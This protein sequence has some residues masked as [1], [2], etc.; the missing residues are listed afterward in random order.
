MNI[1]NVLNDAAGTEIVVRSDRNVKWKRADGTDIHSWGEIMSTFMRH[2]FKFVAAAGTRFSIRADGTFLHQ[3]AIYTGRFD[4]LSAALDRVTG[5][6][7]EECICEGYG[8]CSCA[9]RVANAGEADAF[10]AAYRVQREA[11]LMAE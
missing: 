2:G 6:L 10:D 5:E 1:T 4:G 7:G 8:K 11:E 3:D 9:L